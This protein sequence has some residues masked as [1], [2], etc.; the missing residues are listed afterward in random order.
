MSAYRAVLRHPVGLP[1]R[2]SLIFIY[3]LNLRNDLTGLIDKDR[4]TYA[5]TQ[6]VDKILVVQ[7]RARYH[8]AA[9]AYWFENS[10]GS[11]SSCPSRIDFDIKKT[12]LLY[13]RRI[14]VGN[15]PS[16]E[17]DCISELGSFR[18]IIELYNRAVDIVFKVASHLTDLLYSFPYLIGSPALKALLDY[19]DAV[20]P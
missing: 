19:L 16:R 18:K 4:I 8:R 13:F 3:I 14:L 2:W 9:K 5:K 12:C 17:L 6:L 7:S 10:Y 11:Y 15:C 1:V 20:A